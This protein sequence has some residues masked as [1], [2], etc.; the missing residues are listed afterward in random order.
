M[1]SRIY[2]PKINPLKWVEVGATANP[3]YHTKHLDT[4]FFEDRAQ[5]WDQR[6]YRCQVWQ[7]TDIIP[8]QFASN[9]APVL[10][11][12]ISEEGQVIT[13][14]VAVN[15]YPWRNSAGFSSYEVFISL[16]GLDTGHYY[17]EM[18]LGTGSD[19]KTLRSN[20]F[21]ISDTPLTNTI[22]LE[23]SHFEHHEDV[24]FE[25]G[26]TFQWRTAGYI[27]KLLPGMA[28]EIYT[29]QRQNPVSLSAVPF[30]QFEVYF[31]SEFGATDDDLDL[32]NRIHTCSYVAYDG[33]QFTAMDGGKFEFIEA[34]GSRKRGFKLKVQ[35]TINRPSL[36]VGLDLNPNKKI[37]V[38]LNVDGQTFGDLSGQGNTV[39]ITKSI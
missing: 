13:S 29:D 14:A 5:P 16:A 1:A 26:I 25:T 22:L 33:K 35:P 17:G 7:T 15:A 9:F 31:N 27:S 11:K 24:M 38:L 36:A 21:Y 37:V 34:E 30:N 12:L 32:L 3:K 18:V 4:A 2:I 20:D 23:Y 39:P 28:Q 10:V 19:T 8:Q 6:E